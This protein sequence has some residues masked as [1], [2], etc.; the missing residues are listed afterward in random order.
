[1][2]PSSA[3][4]GGGGCY[5]T[6]SGAATGEGEGD[7]ERR[8]ALVTLGGMGFGRWSQ[9]SVAATLTAEKKNDKARSIH[10][11]ASPGKER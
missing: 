9:W 1:M 5:V 10:G 7:R 11:S 2:T 6:K 8:G 4:A 3:F